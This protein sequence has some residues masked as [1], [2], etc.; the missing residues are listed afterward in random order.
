MEEQHE[1]GT[2]LPDPILNAFADRHLKEWIQNDPEKDGKKQDFRELDA[3]A[4]A[5]LN[6]E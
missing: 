1:L 4:L 3:I 6:E 2:G 5:I